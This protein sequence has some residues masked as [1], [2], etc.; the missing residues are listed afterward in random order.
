MNKQSLSYIY[1]WS[2]I[3]RDQKYIKGEDIAT[4]A[5]LLKTALLQRGIQ[6]KKIRRKNN[7]FKNFFNK[8]IPS[9]IIVDFYQQLA[10]LLQAGLAITTALELYS[11]SCSNLLMRQLII[12]IQNNI[13]NGETLSRSL[14]KY[15]QYFNIFCCHLIYAGEQIGDIYSMLEK[16]IYYNKI[17]FTIKNKIKKSLLYP[18]F[19]LFFSILIIFILIYYIIPELQGLFLDFSRQ[20]PVYT[21]FII[22]ISN[23][24]RN[25]TYIF[26]IIF[27]LLFYSILYI[28]KTN[29]IKI[30]IPILNIIIEKYF[31]AIWSHTL[32]STLS[33]G[34]PLSQALYI[35]IKTMHSPDY[36]QAFQVIKNKITQGQSMYA[37]MENMKLFP[38]RIKQ[39]VYIGEQSG[40]LVAVLSQLSLACQTEANDSIEIA[41]NILEPLLII[42]LG[43]IIGG[44]V[45]A[46]Y[47]PIFKLGSIV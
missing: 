27:L 23:T 29:T 4:S 20:L 7:I 13:E 22:F 36:K 15:P 41:L 32:A 17:I 9:K 31:T 44:I 1:Y 47:L 28:L 45:I 19:I 33:A 16:I 2:G 12:D 38:L 39:M 40:T 35:V 42:I 21:Q 8:K 37:A 18:M 24:L 10:F 30:K 5:L 11:Q 6:V 25:N 3:T 26:I 14:E 43:V 46:M 34:I